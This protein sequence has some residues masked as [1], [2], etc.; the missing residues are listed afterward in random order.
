M[1]GDLLIFDLDGVI[2]FGERVPDE[3]RNLLRDLRAAGRN[4]RFLTND[5]IN[6]RWCRLS[7]LQGAG[8][9]VVLEEIYT[10]SYLASRYLRDREIQP[11]LPLFGERAAKEF[12]GIARSSDSPNAVVVGDYF[13]HYDY[14]TLKAAFRALDR[15]AELVAMHK[16][17]WWPIGGERVIDIG[18][19]VAGL[20]YCAGAGA[21]VVGKPA[22]FSY[23][24]V[25]RDLG[26]LPGDAVMIADQVD[27]D[28]IGAH[29]AGIRTLLLDEAGQEPAGSPA[30]DQVARSYAELRQ[31][32]A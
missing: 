8:V 15:G 20:E 6:S 17:P 29:V 26:A 30:V 21:T 7:Q 25:L 10:T 27:P 19:W 9:E 2:Q 23:E 32:L 4:L 1:S 12:E 11:I 13:P 28:L 31:I 18:F 3:A 14:E 24:T 16:K 22:A 5:G